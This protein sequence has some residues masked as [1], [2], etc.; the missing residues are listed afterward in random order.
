ME[1]WKQTAIFIASILFVF[2]V[3]LATHAIHDKAEMVGVMEAALEIERDKYESLVSSAGYVRGQEQK[4]VFPFYA[5][6]TVQV[7]SHF[8]KRSD[9]FQLNIG[10]Y[11]PEDKMHLGVDIVSRKNTAIRAPFDGYVIEHFPPPNGYWKGDGVRGGKIVFTDGEFEFIY[12]HLGF[13]YV[14]SVE[15]ENFYEAGETIAR[16]GDTGLTTGPHLHLEV[17][18]E[19]SDGTYT[20]YDPLDFFDIRVDDENYILFPENEIEYIQHTE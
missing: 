14:S 17:R 20:Y 18:K 6:S 7:T 3:S 12:S 15:G 2:L 11:Q 19:N 5:N 4:L 8:E 1:L 10:P 16:M 9:P 13:T